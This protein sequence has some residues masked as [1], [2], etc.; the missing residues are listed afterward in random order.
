MKKNLFEDLLK[1]AF[2]E[3]KIAHLQSI[4]IVNQNDSYK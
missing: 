2:I 3:Q 1:E 4:V